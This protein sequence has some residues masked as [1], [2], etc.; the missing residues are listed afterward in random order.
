MELEI[1]PQLMLGQG[2]GELICACI[3]GVLSL[4]DALKLAST[5]DESLTQ[6]A[7]KI[8]LNTP[9]IQFISQTT[10]DFITTS[11]AEDIEYWT[12]KQRQGKGFEAGLKKVILGSEQLL[13]DMGLGEARIT[14]Y[15]VCYTKLLRYWAS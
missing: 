4:E 5:E 7:D 13:L 3:S 6:I 8:E 15:N 12:K 2:V 9:Q 10:G 11:E 1:T 14:S